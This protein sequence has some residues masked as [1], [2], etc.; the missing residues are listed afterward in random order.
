MCFTAQ[1]DFLLNIGHLEAFSLR[2]WSLQFYLPSGANIVESM[3]KVM[4][5]LLIEV[6]SATHGLCLLFFFNS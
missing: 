3:W 1:G 5:V 4:Y 2:N 6:L